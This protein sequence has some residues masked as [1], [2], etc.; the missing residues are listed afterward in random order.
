MVEGLTCFRIDIRHVQL[1]ENF[2]IY[3]EEGHL[4][5]SFLYPMSL[6]G[7]ERRGNP[8]NCSVP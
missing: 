6:P 8:S 5:P 7:A 3:S 1:L 4:S 2:Y